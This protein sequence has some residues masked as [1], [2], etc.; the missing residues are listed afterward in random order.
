[1]KWYQLSVKEISEKLGISENGLNE[2][3]VRQRLLQYGPNKLAEEE[4]ISRLKIPLHQFTSPLIYILLIA[5]V[6]T[7]FL[8][9]YIDSGVVFAVVILNAIVGYFQEYEAGE[10]VRALRRMVVSKAKVIRDGREKEIRSEELVPGDIVLL[11]SGTRV[12]ADLRIIH[13]IEL[14]TDESLLTGESLPVEKTYHAL[15][16]ENLIP[17]DQKNMAFMGTVVVNGRA[18]G[19]AVETAAKTVLGSIAREVKEIG[20]VKAPL[21]EKIHGFTKAIGFIVLGTSVALFFIG[22]L[23]G[24][25]VRDMFMT[26]VAA[27]VATIPEGLPI[28]VTIAMA[29]GVA[30]MA[31]QNAIIRKLPAVETLGSTMVIGS[32]KTGTLTKKWDDR[33][34]DL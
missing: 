3:E 13:A 19:I 6:V 15:K 10:S 9:E 24:E 17:G 20:T 1:M 11:A 22:I 23:I 31:K 29:V 27:A 4:K 21:Q 30:R 25:S 2:E 12:P 33:K 26:A 18:K 14:K 34:I 28:V 8:Q 7:I 16:E 32:D 5:G